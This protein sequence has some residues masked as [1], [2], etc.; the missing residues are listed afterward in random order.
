MLK[1]EVERLVLLGILE[2]ENYSEWGAP[3]FA[4]PKLKPNQVHLLSAFKN[5]NKKLKQKP[6]PVPKINDMLLKSK[7][8]QY[9]KSLDLNMG[10]YHIQLRKTQVSYVQLFFCGKNNGT[11]VYQWE[12]RTHRTFPAE[13]G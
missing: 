11:S 4:Q 5:P 6:Y 10:Y 7:G 13:N 12:L 2:V 9:A 1:K 3:S 8:F